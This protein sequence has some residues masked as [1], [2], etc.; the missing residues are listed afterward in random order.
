MFKN[1][2]ILTLL[3]HPDDETLGCGGTLHRAVSEGAEVLCLISVKR[4]IGSCIEAL[5]VLGVQN[6]HF[7]KYVDNQMDTYPLNLVSAFFEAQIQLFKPDIVI[8]H[9]WNCLNQ[10]HRVCYQAGIIATRNSNAQLWCCEIPSSTGYLKPVNFEP[11]LYITLNN[12]NKCSKLKAMGWYN[13]E[14]REYPNIR[15]LEKLQ[16]HLEYRGGEINKKYA[17][18]FVKIREIV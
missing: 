3:A 4:I 11:N 8:L 12:R 13:T 18:A 10:D 2:R 14:L 9:H 7:G 5:K 17:E 6:I 16:N 1:K 15:S